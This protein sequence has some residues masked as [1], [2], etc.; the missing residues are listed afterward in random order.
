MA[1][2]WDVVPRAGCSLRWLFVRPGNQPS[3][4]NPKQSGALAVCCAGCLP[5][6]HVDVEGRG[7]TTL[8]PTR[9][10]HVSQI[11]I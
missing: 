10:E 8:T 7:T 11:H 3:R 9:S 5:V 6:R 4:T 1:T 2:N